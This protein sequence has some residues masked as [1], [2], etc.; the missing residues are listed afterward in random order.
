MD[1]RAFLAVVGAVGAGCTGGD[2]PSDP[3]TATETRTATATATPAPT[4]EFQAASDPWRNTEQ[5]ATD[6]QQTVS[7]EIVLPPNTYAVR[8]PEPA[9]PARLELD[10][11][12]QSDAT[13]DVFL[14]ERSEFE[15]Y[16][17]Q[18]EFLLY[19]EPSTSDVSTATIEHR[20]S[21]GEHAIV[22]DHTTT[23]TPPTDRRVR[24]SYDL[25][26]SYTEET[27]TPTPEPTT[28]R[29]ESLPF[30][31]F[32]TIEGVQIAP[33]DLETMNASGLPDRKKRVAVTV[34]ASNSTDAP[35][36]PPPIEKFALWR[37][38]D[39][40]W[41]SEGMGRWPERLY[42]DERT[43]REVW[44]AVSK[45]ISLGSLNVGYRYNDTLLKWEN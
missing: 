34:V 17:E 25:L 9:L 31:Q 14:M 20:L 45:V 3:A 19:T 26:V 36:T 40:R 6:V 38:D 4:P 33:L 41:E 8:F 7:G 30:G 22:F 15:R 29:P 5:S 23:G 10:I 16:R 18:Q 11:E 42:P 13:I 39:E 35:L 1:R 2:Q 44:F 27:A 12:V 37:G 24:I 28:P 32:R 43:T 21:A